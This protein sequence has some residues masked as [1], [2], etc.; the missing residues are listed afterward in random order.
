MSEWLIG[1]RHVSVCSIYLYFSELL[2]QGRTYIVVDTEEKIKSNMC[3][4]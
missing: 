1:E 2:W 4:T 3:S